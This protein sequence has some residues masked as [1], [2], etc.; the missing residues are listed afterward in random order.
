[1]GAPIPSESAALLAN[2]VE[3]ALGVQ[4]ATSATG[5]LPWGES[6]NRLHWPRIDHGYTSDCFRGNR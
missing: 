5:R 2:G 3:F 1:V 4:N 6:L